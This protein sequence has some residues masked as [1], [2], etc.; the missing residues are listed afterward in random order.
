VTD[1]SRSWS[2][3]LGGVAVLALA[4]T[5]V[6]AAYLQARTDIPDPLPTH[7]DLG[8]DVDG[9]TS[10]AGFTAGALGVSA[11][12]ASVGI[13]LVVLA[14]RER[15]W[16]PSAVF[17][18]WAAWLVVSVY[19][20]VV[21]EAHGERVAED[22]GGPGPV[23][24]LVLAIPLVAALG[25]WALLSRSSAQT[26]GDRARSAPDP[27]A[28]RVTWVGHAS[29][30]AALVGAA[31]LLL[32]ALGLTWVSWSLALVVAVVAG[33][34][35]WGHVLTVRVDNRAITVAWGPGRWPRIVVPIER[36]ERAEAALI[37]PLRW[38]GWGYRATPRGRAAVVRR[39][40]GLVITR[41]SGP[42]LAVTVDRPEGG[43]AL[44]DALTA[45]RAPV[46]RRSGSGAP[47]PPAS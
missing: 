17:A 45:D 28:E 40:P 22:A 30:A 6:L 13:A 19:V 23:V 39:G 14:R 47:T 38:G 2:A 34:V 10:V 1:H 37:D 41:T 24:L 18:T 25:L 20:A 3:L 35:A 36:V 44:V 26:P 16:R 27:S 4:P 11:V 32:L 46:T 12:L 7:W 29:S 33:V 8:G 43:A 9:T 21:A 31:A 42:R 5:T 15:A